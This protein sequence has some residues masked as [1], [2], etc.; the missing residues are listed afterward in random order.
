MKELSISQKKEWAQSLYTKEGLTIAKE[1]ALK[2]GVTEKTMGRW[3]NE[4]EWKTLKRSLLLTRQEQLAMLYAELE[5]INTHIQTK[6]EG[7]KF[8]DSKEAD[9]RRK[10]VKDIESLEQETSL[11]DIFN[12]ARMMLEFWRPL[13]LDKT[14]I[15]TEAFDA[16]IV[17]R[18]Q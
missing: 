8:A 18:L 13:D 2:V 4:G 11:N 12:V 1:L 10:L 3:I 17:S 9:A 7:K 5:Q 14:K 15:L 6:P 16:L